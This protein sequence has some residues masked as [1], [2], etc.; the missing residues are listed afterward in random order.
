[1]T[2]VLDRSRRQMMNKKDKYVPTYVEEEWHIVGPGSVH[3][4]R[5]QVEGTFAWF[6][7]SRYCIVFGRLQAGQ[8][9]IT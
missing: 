7:A 5:D 6:S 4:L 3:M 8:M 2:A 9:L 1:M